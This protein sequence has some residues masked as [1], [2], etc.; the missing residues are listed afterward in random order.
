MSPLLQRFFSKSEPEVREPVKE[1]PLIPLFEQLLKEGSASSKLEIQKEVLREYQAGSHRHV[2]IAAVA[3]Y[4]Q[5]EE[6]LIKHDSRYRNTKENLRASVSQQFPE[7]NQFLSFQLLTH[8]EEA[9]EI[10]LAQLF[11]RTTLERFA[12]MP[13]F[14]K[15]AKIWLSTLNFEPLPEG[16]LQRI[17]HIRQLRKIGEKSYEIQKDLEDEQ[18]AQVIQKVFQDTHAYFLTAFKTLKTTRILKNLLPDGLDTIIEKSMVVPKRPTPDVPKSLKTVSRNRLNGSTAAVHKAMLENLLDAYMLFDA[19]GSILEVND[20]APQVFGCDRDELLRQSIF[21][22]LP[23]EISKSL[24]A[25]L[26]NTSPGTVKKILGTRVETTIHEEDDLMDIELTFTNNYSEVF[27]TYTVL[28]RNISNKKDSLKAIEEV[29]ANAERTAKAKSTFLSNMSHEIRTPLNVILGLSDIISN[30]D[31]SDETILR[32]NLEGISFSAENLLTIVNDILDF[33]KI[34][35]GKLSIQEMDFNLQKAIDN[36][37][38]GFGIKAR[39]KGLTLKSNV[40]EDIP[41]VVIGDQ[42]RINQILVNLVG[43]AIKFTKEGSISVN[44]RKKKEDGDQIHLEFEVSDT[45]IGIPRDQLERI[46]ESFYQVE[47]PESAKIKG[48]G[49]GLA[50]T[51]ELIALQGGSL[52]AN[53]TVGQGSAFCFTLPLKKSKLKAVDTNKTVSGRKDEELRGLRILVAE[54]NNMNQFYIK[55]LLNKLEIIVDIAE[56]GKEAVEM[57]EKA[58]KQYDLVLMDMHMP[59]M[60]GLEAVEHIRKSN[61]NTMKKIPIVACSADVFPEARKKAVKAGIDFYLT[62]PLSEESLKEVLFW[63]IGNELEEPSFSLTQNPKYSLEEGVEKS[64]TLDMNLLNETFDHDEEFII[65]LLEVFVKDTPDDYTSLRHCIDREFHSRATALAHKMK[66]SFMN[67]G[68][69]QHGYHL[70]K[71]EQ[72]LAQGKRLDEVKQHLEAFGAIY[73]KALLEVNVTLIDLKHK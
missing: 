44:V 29:K 24:A 4:L 27:D 14:A 73:S 47:H 71:M 6:Y 10:L 63:L 22:L 59:I 68:L 2:E 53:S 19:Q 69:T 30:S 40:A 5:I 72:L 28:I 25:D 56:N 7:V 34:E 38:N 39:E 61:R 57:F 49:L 60:N 41:E 42:Y 66:S 26:R 33:S 18:N 54:D 20:L 67:L 35:A 48:T 32:K 43:N 31:L 1:N 23:Q 17:D 51:K 9:Q 21:D 70:Q 65:S 12:Q 46:F 11:V 45:G 37:A 13:A 50:I 15:A 16:K 52:E 62:K 8:P 3:T 58:D 36:L 55:Q 64:T